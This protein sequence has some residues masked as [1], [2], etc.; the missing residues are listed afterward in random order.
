MV[1]RHIQ[2]FEQYIKNSKDPNK[3]NQE[4]EQRKKGNHPDLGEDEIND[5]SKEKD[6][7]YELEEYFEKRKNK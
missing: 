6:M 7:A 4:N 2:L 5:E 1:G 3:E